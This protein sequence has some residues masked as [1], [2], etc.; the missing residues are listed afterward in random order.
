[1][2]IIDDI[3]S[4]LHYFDTPGKAFFNTVITNSHL[5]PFY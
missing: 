3:D 2:Y 4:W 5:G 1:M